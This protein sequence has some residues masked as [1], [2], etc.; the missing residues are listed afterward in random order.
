MKKILVTGHTG[1]LG[2][3]LVKQLSKK[4]KILGISNQTPENPLI[5]QIKKDIRKVKLNDIPNDISYIIHLAAITD[6]QYCQKYPTECF[7]VNVLGTQNLLELCRKLNSK[8]IYFSTSH[9]YGIPK[10][11]PLD[12]NH[13]LC[14]I[15][16][17]A[18]SKLAAEIICKSY[19][20]SYN[21]DCAVLRI[22]SVYGPK[23]P[24]YLVTSRIISQF[25]MKNVLEL[26]NVN[27]KRDFIFVKD[28]INA[29]EF[30][31]KKSKQ[32]KIYNVGNGKSCS[33]LDLCNILESI[34]GKK[35]TIKSKRSFLRKNDINNMFSNN[36]NLRQLGWKPKVSLNEG[37]QI[38]FD[39][40][41]LNSK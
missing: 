29:V 24:R 27:S 4:Y 14:P 6:V 37:L 11:L 20:E 23:S 34:T 38:T 28:V 19:S 35:I 33:I 25:L 8:F 26:G 15:S 22:F 13:T 2:S 32:Y 7:N 10:T 16:N 9:V 40:F 5:K 39:W 3:H 12:E 21:M 30:V 41:A 31:M 17:Y 1:F 18:A 36:F